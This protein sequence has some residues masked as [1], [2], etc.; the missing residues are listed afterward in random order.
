MLTG[1][2]L[3]Y[4]TTLKMPNKKPPFIGIVFSSVRKACTLNVHL[5]NQPQDIAYTLTLLQPSK[6]GVEIRLSSDN[7]K[8]YVIYQ[9]VKCDVIQLENFLFINKL[10]QDFNFGHILRDFDRDTVVC[11]RGMGK[12]FVLKIK[13]VFMMA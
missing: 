3:M 7:K 6:E 12:P 5:I 4:G 9:R 2:I 8:D 11:T 1:V 13:G 10:C